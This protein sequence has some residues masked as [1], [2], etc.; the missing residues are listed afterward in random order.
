MKSRILAFPTSFLLLIICSFLVLPACSI[1]DDDEG[2]DGPQ[3]RAP[4]PLRDGAR[5]RARETGAAGAD[6]AEIRAFVG[7]FA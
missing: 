1:D 5:L 6:L 4:R 7:G 2:E 3:A